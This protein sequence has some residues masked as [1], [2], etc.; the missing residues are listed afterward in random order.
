MAAPV[1][2]SPS[3][4]S[5]S[6]PYRTRPSNLQAPPP[7]WFFFHEFSDEEHRHFLDSCSLC[8]KPLAGNGDI[9]MYRGDMPFCSVEC[10]LEQIEIDEAREKNWK[11]QSSSSIPQKS[12]KMHV[13]AG[14]VVAG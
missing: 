13:R 9:F 8:K 1:L 4:S 10:R 2:S 5:G 3:S 11:K 14:T 7:L 12:Q 6:S